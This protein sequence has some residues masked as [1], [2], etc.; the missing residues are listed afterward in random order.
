[1]WEKPECVSGIK[2]AVLG[3]YVRGGDGVYTLLWED[4]EIQVTRLRD[5]GNYR[6]SWKRDSAPVV[7]K[8][9]ISTGD[10]QEIILDD[11]YIHD[12]TCP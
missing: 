9:T 10:G 4:Q 7:G 8:L 6:L 1:M 5:L 11:I 3:V 2:M 12:L